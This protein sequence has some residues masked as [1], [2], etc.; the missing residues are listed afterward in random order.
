MN[1]AVRDH[2]DLLVC[3]ESAASWA[4]Q[5]LREIRVPWD[6]AVKPGP[7]VKTVKRV[8]LVRMACLVLWDLLPPKVL[9]EI[10]DFVV[11]RDLAD[12]LERGDHLEHL[13]LR[14][15]LV[16]WDNLGLEVQRVI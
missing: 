5:E 16:Q 8:P 15:C 13:E 11:S 14:V 3:L 6:P 12:P 10:V 2:R 4:S 7:M 1:Q 9:L